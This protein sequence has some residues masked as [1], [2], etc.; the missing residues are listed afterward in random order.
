MAKHLFIVFAF[1]FAFAVV[2]AGPL[3]CSTPTYI[4]IPPENGDW[5]FSNPN[6]Q[7]VQ[8]IQV[9][10]IR[11][12][13]SS[14]PLGGPYEVLLPERTRPETYAWVVHTLGRDALVPGGVPAVEL[15]GHGRP[16]K[17]QTPP[18]ASDLH[19]QLGDFPAVEVRS[20]RI[21]GGEGQVDLVR[22][23]NTGRRLT[24]V[25]LELE[26]GHGWYAKRVRNW[27]VDPDTQPVPLG[28]ANPVKPSDS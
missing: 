5:A 26:A 7:D 24:T 12:S 25:Y 2:A 17:D 1:A 8:R 18:A 23:G 19:P 21:R 22:S 27:R 11:K 16:V 3:A 4:N 28:P 15:D 9:A 14:D 10:A 20:V 13:V 6:A